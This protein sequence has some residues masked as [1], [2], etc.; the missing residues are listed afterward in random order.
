MLI[1][2]KIEI[3]VTNDGKQNLV[4]V[5]MDLSVN[6]ND[7]M[8]S[9]KLAEKNIHAALQAYLVAKGIKPTTKKLDKLLKTLT[10][11]QLMDWNEKHNS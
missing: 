7:A 5:G 2:C 11:Q 8:T 9:I 1:D 3:T 10:V 4:S 6:L